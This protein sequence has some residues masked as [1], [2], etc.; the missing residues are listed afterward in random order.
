MEQKL[1]NWFDTNGI[2][3]ISALPLAQCRV[4]APGMLRR[5]NIGEDAGVLM[6]LIPYYTRVCD[7]P[8]V[9]RT[10]SVYSVPRDYHGCFR[11]ISDTLL[12]LLGELYPGERFYGFA[13]SSPIAEADAAM[14]AGL[15]DIGLHGLLINER[16]S[17]FAFIAEVI[18]T[19]P[20]ERFGVP[21]RE[22]KRLCGGASCRRCVEACPGRALGGER[23]EA[24]NCLSAIT[25]KKGELTPEQTRAIA[26]SG[27]AWG[28]D[29]C[30]LACPYTEAARRAGTIYT[31]VPYM[32]AELMPSPRYADIAA[33]PEEE[34]ACRAYSWRGRETLLRDLK[35]IEGDGRDG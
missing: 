6:F 33:M 15:G 5:W 17:S 19:M 1:K 26:E 8:D 30:S 9:R 3:E 21:V 13:D 4:I 34:F 11:Q 28:C 24:G 16:Y 18:S 22:Y 20:A 31:R 32:N 29:V 25:Q 23:F 12:P 35:I 14:K 2:E 10:V 7:D 27:C